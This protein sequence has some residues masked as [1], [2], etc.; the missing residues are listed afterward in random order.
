MKRRIELNR[1]LDILVIYHLGS[2]TLTRNERIFLKG[3]RF[4]GGSSDQE[5][6]REKDKRSNV[7]IVSK[8]IMDLNIYRAMNVDKWISTEQQDLDFRRHP[9]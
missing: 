4:N 9:D 8:N 2:R 5:M 3:Q 6:K 1:K 7:V